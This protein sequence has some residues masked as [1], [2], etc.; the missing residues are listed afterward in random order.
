MKFNILAGLKQEHFN[1]SAI[2]NEKFDLIAEAIEYAREH[3]E[4]LYQLNPVRD[5]LEI[6]KE[7]K[8][9]E[10]VATLTFKLEMFRNIIYYVEE[11]VESDGV[12][13]E[14]IRHEWR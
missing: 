10:D 8:V 12:V 4:S 11:L 7:D 2:E 1:L 9:S 3:A 13:I 14:K 6:M 5:I